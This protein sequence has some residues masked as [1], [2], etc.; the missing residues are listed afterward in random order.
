MLIETIDPETGKTRRVELADENIKSHFSDEEIKEIREI[1]DALFQIVQRAKAIPELW[2]VITKH[3][4]F[5]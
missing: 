4:R 2:E 3:W 5:S 1:V